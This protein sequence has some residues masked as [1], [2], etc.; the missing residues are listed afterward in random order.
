MNLCVEVIDYYR[1]VRFSPPLLL[2]FLL[3]SF[4]IHL[5]EQVEYWLPMLMMQVMDVMQIE[6]KYVQ[7]EEKMCFRLLLL[8]KANHHT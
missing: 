6:V 7:V 2:P 8:L 1:F 5:L 4:H 3:Q